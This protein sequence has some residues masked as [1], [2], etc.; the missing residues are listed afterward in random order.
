MQIVMAVV[1][2]LAAYLL[3]SI[4]W[5]LVIVRLATG[6][7][8]RQVGSGRTGGTNAMRAAGFWAGLVTAMLDIGKGVVGVYLARWLVPGNAWLEILA[9][10]ATVLGHNYS[11]F[12][13]EKTPQGGWRLRGG[14]GGT[15]A[16][17]GGIGLWWPLVLILIPLGAAIFYF[18]GYASVATLS[19]AAI[20]T[21]TFMI[22]AWLG[23]T[24]WQYILYGL[25]VFGLLAWSLRPN[26][27]RLM[28]GTERLHG[29]RAQMARRKA[30]RQ[31]NDHSSS[32][33]SSSSSS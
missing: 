17:G 19:A 16:A 6:Q 18:V 9:A 13:T 8:V 12:L 25:V 2:L 14:A 32:S 15:P 30:A 7:D 5:G 21:I 22:T 26:L 20:V 23:I 29:F 24:P 10:T 3:G 31:Q 27:A 33:N 11:V 4:P 28:N 1:V